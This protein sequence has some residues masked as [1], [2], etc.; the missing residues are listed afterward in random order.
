[1]TVLKILFIIMV[2][3][4]KFLNLVAGIEDSCNGF[5]WFWFMGLGLYLMTLRGYS[6]LC[7]QKLIL[8]W[9]FS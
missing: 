9:L 6:Q 5:I 8:A 1:M 2:V 7:A 4:A 3:S